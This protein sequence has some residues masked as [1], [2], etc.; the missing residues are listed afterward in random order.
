MCYIRID[1]AAVFPGFKINQA[2]NESWI[3]LNYFVSLV[4]LN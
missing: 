4:A 1:L 2:T 3:S